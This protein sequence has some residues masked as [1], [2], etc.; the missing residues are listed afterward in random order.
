M[1]PPA[2]RRLLRDR[3]RSSTG[4]P[5]GSDHHALREERLHGLEK[6][7]EPIVVH[8]MTGILERDGSR[9]LELRIASRDPSVELS[10]VLDPATQARSDIP[11]PV[12]GP[13]AAAKALDRDEPPDR[14]GKD[15][16]IVERD[17]GSP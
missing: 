5:P 6:R 1:A 10:L 16:R 14:L 11:P 7:L 15:A 3:S 12:G 2:T 8:P 9:V 17:G 4:A 13:S